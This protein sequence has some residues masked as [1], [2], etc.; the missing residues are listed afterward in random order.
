MMKIIGLCGGSGSGK[1]TACAAMEALG[2]RIIDTDR[3]YREICVAGSDCLADI[4]REFGRAAVAPDGGLDRRSLGAIV[5]SDAEA[6]GRLNEIA[7]AHIRTETE[8]RLTEYKSSGADAVVVDAPLL[9]ESGFDR[10]CDI[11]VGITAPR[12]LRIARITAR[13][14]I[15]EKDA[16]AR[17]DSQITD[18]ELIRLCGYIIENGEDKAAFLCRVRSFY[19]S[20]VG[21]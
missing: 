16:E 19:R 15:S 11:T 7:H 5:F 9:F 18:E 10:M 1:T 13:D 3:V 6:R 2:A 21:G 14:G 12:K 17:I 20:A 4:A 8:R